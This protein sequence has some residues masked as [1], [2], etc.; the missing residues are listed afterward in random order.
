MVL[1]C[2]RVDNRHAVGMDFAGGIG[3]IHPTSGFCV[4]LGK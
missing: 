2:G 4:L 1:G 3:D